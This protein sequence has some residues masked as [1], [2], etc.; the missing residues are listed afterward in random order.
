M[1]FGNNI[2]KGFLSRGDNTFTFTNSGVTPITIGLL[3]SNWVFT[4]YPSL[5]SPL[6]NPPVTPS[7]VSNADLVDY[8]KLL[9]DKEM[10]PKDIKGIRLLVQNQNQLYN[11]LLFNSQDANG[12][13]KSFAEYPI[14]FLSPDQFQ[15]RLVEIYYKNLIV[16]LKQ[17]LAYT[18]NAGETVTF[19]FL[20]D[21][22]KL[23]NILGKNPC[24]EIQYNKKDL[25][26]MEKLL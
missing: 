4:A 9:N 10:N 1:K 13:M 20:Y 7:I 11:P 5:T 12:E 3:A 15:G 18:I 24:R 21:E 26:L 19:T 6:G 8:V 25:E 22:F 17:Y 23:E 2:Q 14:N 16:G